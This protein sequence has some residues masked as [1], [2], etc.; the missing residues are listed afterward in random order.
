MKK[1]TKFF[2]FF[3]RFTSCLQTFWN[4]VL[5]EWIAYNAFLSKLRTQT[6]QI[7]AYY[8]MFYHRISNFGRFFLYLLEWAFVF[9]RHNSIDS[10]RF[11]LYVKCD[12]EGKKKKMGNGMPTNVKKL[13]CH[14][15]K[16]ANR[17]PFISD[18]LNMDLELEYNFTI[19]AQRIH[20]KI[21]WLAVPMQLANY[22][23]SMDFYFSRFC[24]QIWARLSFRDAI[25]IVVI[26][27]R[28]LSINFFLS[29]ILP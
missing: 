15:L 17:N 8:T 29:T 23:I 12:F 9:V 13:I 24:G 25:E 14:C 26:T 10:V 11:L 20:L 28:Q 3:L 4:I 6:K 7:I 2:R 1:K 27:T 22:S 19:T 18:H 5:V 16:N 21:D